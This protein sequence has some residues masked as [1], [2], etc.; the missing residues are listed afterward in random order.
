MTKMKTKQAV[1]CLAVAI[2]ALLGLAVPSAYGQAAANN[3]PPGQPFGRP[4]GTPPNQPGPPDGRPPAYPPGRCQL[5]LS[6]SSGSRGDTFQATG[7][8]FQPG[9]R[10]EL[11]LA[12]ALLTTVTADDTG[13]FVAFMTVP[14]DAAAGLTSVR[15]TAA[16]L[17]LE[18][19]FEVLPETT[20]ARGGR[21]STLP[22]TGTAALD[23]ASVG[24][25][26]VVLGATI[27]IIVR[28]RQTD[29][30]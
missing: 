1:V 5:A 12:G 7:S 20:A 9:E 3:C 4:P 23:L 21:S 6:Q 24:G 17:Q 28:R 27:V 22:R 2:T 15:A 19:A 26:L 11:A 10:V 8:G 25:I 30:A 14:A 13:S 16:S 18:A 29:L